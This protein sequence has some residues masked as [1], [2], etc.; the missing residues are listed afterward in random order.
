MAKVF[1]EESTLVG[2]ADLIRESKGT[3][4]LYDPADFSDEFREIIENGSGNS[5]STI[6]GGFTVNFYSEDGV[7]IESHSAECSR[8]VYPPSSF[9]EVDYWTDE[10]DVPYTFPFTSTVSA[11]Y[12]LYATTA[13]TCEKVLYDYFGIDK[14]THPQL[15]IYSM[16]DAGAH[17]QIVIYFGNNIEIYGS[18]KPLARYALYQVSSIFAPIFDNDM[19]AV[20]QNLVATKLSAYNASLTGYSHMG[21]LGS[22]YYANYEIGYDGLNGR[23]DEVMFTAGD[24]LHPYALQEKTATE[25]G[26]VIPDDDYYGLSK[27]IID[28]ETELNLQEKT[29]TENGEVI[30]DEGYNGLS[31]VIVDVEAEVIEIEPTLQ[32][33]TITENGEFTADV[34]Y[35]GLSKVTVNVQPNLQEKTVTENGEV[36]ADNEYDGLSKVVVNIETVELMLQSITINENGVYTADE[37]YNG[38]GE[39]TVEVAG[40]SSVEGGFTV[41]FY[42]EEGELIESHSAELGRD[43]Y[44][45]ASFNEVN[46]WADAEGVPYT[47]PLTINEADTV[48]DLYATEAQTCA[49]VLYAHFGVDSAVRKDVCVDIQADGNYVH[50]YFGN[51]LI[52]GAS[53]TECLSYTLKNVKSTYASIMG[54]MLSV[55][56]ALI[57]TPIANFTTG[58]GYVASYSTHYYYPNFDMDWGIVN[59]RLDEVMF[60]TADRPHPYALQEKTATEPGEVVPDEGYYGLSKVTVDVKSNPGIEGGFTVNFYDEDNALI[61]S[62]SVELGVDIYTPFGFD[63]EY[64]ADSDG[65]YYNFPLTCDEAGK[66]IDLYVADA[67]ICSKLIY[68]HCGVDQEEYP[69]LVLLIPSGRT[70]LT[71]DV[72]FWKDVP[73]YNGTRLTP[74]SGSH[75]LRS[76]LI[77]CANDA[78]N[79]PYDMI[80]LTSHVLS[81]NVSLTQSSDTMYTWA[82]QQTTEGAAGTMYTNFDLT[83]NTK[84]GR[85][86]QTIYDPEGTL[87]RPYA[88]QEKTVTGA[89]EVVPDEGYYGL[90]KVTVNVEGGGEAFNHTVVNSI[91]ADGA[92]YIDTEMHPTPNHT[93]EMEFKVHTIVDDRYDFLFGTRYGSVARYQARFTPSSSTSY[94]NQLRI[95]RCGYGTQTNNDYWY[96]SNLTKENCSDYRIFKLAKNEIYVDGELEGTQTDNIKAENCHYPFSLY[97]FSVNDTE[98]VS[99][100]TTGCGYIACKY[101]KIWD[102]NDNLILDL[103][104]VVKSDGVVCMFDLVNERYYYNAGTGTFAYSTED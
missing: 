41:N 102:A 50:V 99:A 61:E 89:G 103:L 94:Q 93:I 29:V 10:N 48:L 54:D 28:I 78:T 70:N 7:L 8:D 90:S 51:G 4:E 39:V 46:Y 3:T 35:D 58:T 43:I 81:N 6:E 92:S 55:V 66:V 47:L 72:T 57:A 12:N 100:A 76:G 44:A 98:D 15:C 45:P 80:T 36:I 5:S 79:A 26:E 95:Q 32:E 65:V 38:F 56:N 2:M 97:L 84:G 20:V 63:A 104:P 25:S 73:T 9:G 23:L 49:R 101:V 82:I 59:G 40:G 88:L 86:D 1:I 53:A 33:K 64:W 77:T 91:I 18:A 83:N 22:V 31:K 85:L 96:N 42:S 68:Q 21:D 34:D 14:A 19:L 87:V 62:H 24:R 13:Q 17:G 37:G 30:P 11:V 16:Y 69:Y 60:D 71:V 75:C 74:A 67:P 27:V 52:N